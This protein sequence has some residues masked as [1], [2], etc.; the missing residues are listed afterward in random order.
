VFVTLSPTVDS[1]IFS[2]TLENIIFAISRSYLPINSKKKEFGL[3]LEL[4]P[5]VEGV[6]LIYDIEKYHI[7]N[8]QV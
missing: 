3:F 4:L 1:L 7:R 8:Q 5:T 6:A 2:K